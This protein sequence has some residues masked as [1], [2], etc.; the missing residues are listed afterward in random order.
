MFDSIEDLKA[1]LEELLNC[2][3]RLARR[4]DGKYSIHTDLVQN[5]EG[6]IV[7]ID[8]VED[9]EDEEPEFDA[10]G[11][12]GDLEDEENE[13]YDDETHYDE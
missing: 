13:S 6:E 8:D 11:S 5:N 1:Q 3:V 9:N 12:D 4:S 2:E 10:D 7:H